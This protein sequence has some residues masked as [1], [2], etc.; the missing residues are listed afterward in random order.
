[1]H[2]EGGDGFGVSTKFQDLDQISEGDVTAAV[3]R[4]DPEELELVSITI[5]LSGPD[6]RMAEDTCLLLA[7]HRQSRI[8]AHAVMSL[9]YLARRFRRLDEVRVKPVIESALAETDE[10]VRMHAQAAADEICQFLH[11]ASKGM[12]TARGRIP[13]R[14]PVSGG[15]ERNLDR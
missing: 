12:S 1:M 13:L 2:K 15:F 3:E 11:W 8:R 5:A 9:G 7:I 10:Y 4:N 14:C 6:Q